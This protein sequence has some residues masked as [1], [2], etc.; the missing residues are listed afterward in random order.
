VANLQCEEGACALQHVAFEGESDAD[1]M[2]GVAWGVRRFSRGV[3][4]HV[5]GIGEVWM[6]WELEWEVAVGK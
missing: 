5:V 6:G 4:T 2:R 3:V 1:G